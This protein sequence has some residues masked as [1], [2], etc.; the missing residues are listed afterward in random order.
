MIIQNDPRRWKERA[1]G[2]MVSEDRAGIA[3]LS[4]KVMMQEI[5]HHDIPVNPSRAGDVPNYGKP[6]ME[7]TFFGVLG[8][9]K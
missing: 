6:T 9:K 2:S 5:P 4:P 7:A 8:S 3:N 1:D